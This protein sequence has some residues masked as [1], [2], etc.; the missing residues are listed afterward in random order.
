MMGFIGRRDCLPI[1]STTSE[2]P[3]QGSVEKLPSWQT[4]APETFTFVNGGGLQR[5]SLEVACH[6]AHPG[7]PCPRVV[8]FQ[9]PCR[10]AFET[11]GLSL[12]GGREQAA[13]HLPIKP[14]VAKR[15]TWLASNLASRARVQPLRE[16]RAQ[17]YT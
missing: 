17:H 15:K 11:Y 13:R 5:L 10:V 1:G 4:R 2:G 12:F 9:D 14:A 16:A 8:A 7:A 3:P 6:L